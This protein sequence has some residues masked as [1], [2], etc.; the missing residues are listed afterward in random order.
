MSKHRYLFTFLAILLSAGNSALA[1][2]DRE[3]RAI[4][5]LLEAL[6]KA[7]FFSGRVAV[8]CIGLSV[9]SA[10]G[11]E[12]EI[13]VREVHAR[14]CPGDPGAESVIERFRVNITTRRILIADSA[15]GDYGNFVP[16]QKRA[17]DH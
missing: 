5:M 17:S 11:V 3:D 14:K 16:A 13:A 2:T 1:S 12:Y 10:R 4:H 7:H 15:T 9:E 8:D 6:K